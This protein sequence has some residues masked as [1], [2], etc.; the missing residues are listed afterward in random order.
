MCN[1]Y[2]TFLREG[3][4][5]RGNVDGSFITSARGGHLRSGGPPLDPVMIDASPWDNYDPSTGVLH[6]APVTG[7]LHEDE[8]IDL[9]DVQLRVL[10]VTTIHG[11]HD[12]SFGRA[13]ME[14]IIADYTARW[15]R[16][17]A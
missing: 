7:L 17:E 13:R 2:V 10:P 11:G 3:G 9:G 8:V 14:A 16:A 1:P 12:P 15:D 6:P 5:Q 4:R